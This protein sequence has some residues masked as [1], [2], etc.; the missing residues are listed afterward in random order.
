MPPFPSAHFM[1]LG[2]AAAAQI[3]TPP[4]SPS[5]TRIPKSYQP[6]DIGSLTEMV[7][8]LERSS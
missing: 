3:S 4:V 1:D 5:L 7:I 6:C 8:L 2:A